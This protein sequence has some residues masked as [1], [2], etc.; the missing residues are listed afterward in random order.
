MPMV[1]GASDMF[2]PGRLQQVL[3]R[4]P[5]VL[6]TMSLILGSAPRESGCRM[7]VTREE[8][9]GSIGGGN[10]E[11]SACREAREALEQSAATR[12]WHKPYGLGPA[13]N[14]C[15]GGAVTLHFEVLDGGSPPWV[16]QLAGDPSGQAAAPDPIVLVS[17]ID[18]PAPLHFVLRAGEPG[19]ERLPAAVRDEAHSLLRQGSPVPAGS[20]EQGP[21]TVVDDGEGEWWL[22]RIPAN[23]T[24][25]YLFGAGHVGQAVARQLQ[26]LP[27]QV[28]WLDS[29]EGF[30]PEM[31]AGN[32]RTIVAA[33]PAG[34]VARAPANTIYVVMTHSHA[35]DED[36]CFEIFRRG[37]FR[38]LGL[39]GSRTKRKR[40]VQRLNKRGVPDGE[41]ERLVCPI[42]LVGV[43]GKQPATIALS[44][45]AQLMMDST[46]THEN[47]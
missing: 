30:L 39:I 2:W 8:V 4:E 16:E 35:L 28:T 24:S 3:A 26:Y 6:V 43:H 19:D 23:Q 13:L 36:I 5:C 40:F 38:W 10:L 41:L 21:L 14:Q 46:W 42:G 17:A 37:D 34:V 15:C 7:I 32:T 29:R 18:A 47:N 9:F 11:F 20:G 1:H 12:H 27:F 22:E 31:P 25:L 45:A 44:L 33:E